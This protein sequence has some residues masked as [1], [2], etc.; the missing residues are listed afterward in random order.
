MLEFIALQLMSY[1]FSTNLRETSIA[2]TSFISKRENFP[3][4]LCMNAMHT[5]VFSLFLASHP[6]MLQ[7][8][9]R[10]SP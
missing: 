9:F 3:D 2:L 5:S 6:G 1:F 7:F 8:G 4:F 10:F